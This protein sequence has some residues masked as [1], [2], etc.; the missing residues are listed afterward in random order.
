MVKLSKLRS[1]MMKKTKMKVTVKM[2][3]MVMMLCKVMNSKLYI[4]KEKAT[5][6]L[7]TKVVR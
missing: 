5:K 2:Y 1:V 4:V 3:Q 6:M 7:K